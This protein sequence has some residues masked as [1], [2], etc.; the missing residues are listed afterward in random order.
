MDDED[1]GGGGGTSNKLDDVSESA[2]FPLS[3]EWSVIIR[4]APPAVKA[5]GVD[6]AGWCWLG[7]CGGCGHRL[8]Q[9]GRGCRGIPLLPPRVV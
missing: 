6:G 7:W 5:Q 9:A 8:Q 1:L 2:S 4:C 3:R